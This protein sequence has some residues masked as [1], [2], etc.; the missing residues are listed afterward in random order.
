MLKPES[1]L[2]L[3]IKRNKITCEILCEN[4]WIFPKDDS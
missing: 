3:G 2:V 1:W 4:D